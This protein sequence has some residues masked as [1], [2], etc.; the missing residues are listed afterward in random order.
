V[1]VTAKSTAGATSVATVTVTVQSADSAFAGTRTVCLSRGSDFSGCPSGAT[2][3]ANATSW[4]RLQTGYRYLLKAGENFSSL[5][6]LNVGPSIQDVH[7]GSFGSGAKPVLNSVMLL[8]NDPLTTNSINRIVVRDLNPSNINNMIGATDLLLLRNTVTGG[9]MID[10]AGA[11]DFY[12]DH[13]CCTGW[14]NPEN[15]FVVENT[16]D[17]NFNNIENPNGISGNAVK[18]AIMGNTV[19]RTHE[20]NIRIWQAAKLFVAHNNATGVSGGSIRHAL[21]VHSS[22]TDAIGTLTSGVRQRQRTSEVV[23]ADNRFG[24]T[25]SNIN[26]LVAFGP[27]NSEEVEVLEKI[28]AEDNRFAHGS[29]FFLDFHAS[30]RSVTTRGNAQ[31]AGGA[32]RES[33]GG[34]GITPAAWFGPY[35]FGQPSVKGMFSSTTLVPRSPTSLAVE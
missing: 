27:Q 22:G 8:G 32:A 13:S 3:T 2:R 6:N 25:S 10:I 9:G 5:G 19:T 7:V 17:R 30:G 29:N 15:I 21:K 24:S 20:H 16:V 18:F 28:I 34:Q 4:P 33:V 31:A 23:V 26:W 35:Y 12:V 14:K 1:Q 11:F